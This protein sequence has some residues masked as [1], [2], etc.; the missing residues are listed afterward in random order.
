MERKKTVGTLKVRVETKGNGK[1]IKKNV[2]VKQKAT[3]LNPSLLQ[4]L[5]MFTELQ[6][7][8]AANSES[9]GPL[10]MV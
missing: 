2:A 7:Q 9:I 5:T 4:R 8:I 1:R 10:M 3:F 6:P